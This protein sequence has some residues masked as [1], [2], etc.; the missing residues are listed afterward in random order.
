MVRSSIALAV[1]CCL[2]ACNGHAMAGQEL[3]LLDIHPASPLASPSIVDA[4]T[5]T[6]P[7]QQPSASPPAVEGGFV[8]VA[9]GAFLM[10]SAT[11]GDSE[12]PV[13]RVVISRDFE[14]G[15]HEVTQR[16]WETMMGNNPSHFRGADRPVER[17]SWDDAQLFIQKMNARNDG[18]VYRLPT[19]AEWEYAARAGSTA[20]YAGTGNL[21]EMGWHFGN[22]GGTT[23]PVGSRK[24]NAWGLHDTHGN[25]WEWVQDWYDREYYKISPAVDPS[26]P[27]TGSRKTCRGGAWNYGADR[28]TSSSRAHP[29]PDARESFIGFRLVRT[30]KQEL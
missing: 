4:A 18:Y 1:I 9:A 28:S 25:V 21:D 11:A 27:V 22:S 29:A 17:V 8:R 10:G 7:S 12:R 14:I 30:R 24:P 26:G 16:Q 6:A 23:H 15:R 3:P 2:F 19:E 13:H 5:G 20:E